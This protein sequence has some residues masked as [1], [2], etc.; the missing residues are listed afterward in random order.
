MS[1]LLPLKYTRGG[2]KVLKSR[3]FKHFTYALISLAFQSACESK[4]LLNSKPTLLASAPTVAPLDILYAGP[5][6]TIIVKGQNFSTDLSLFI[7]DE[8]IALSI[9]DRERAS[10][11]LPE[12]EDN[13]LYRLSF[14]SSGRPLKNF[15][16][17][18]STALNDLPIVPVGLQYICE[19]LI[20]K[21]Q[22]G[23]ILRG[24]AKCG[25]NLAKPCAHD[26]EVNC[27]ANE[28]FKAAATLDAA[29][30]ILPGESLAGIHGSAPVK[31]DC[32]SDGEGNCVVD[33]LAYKAAKLSLFSPYDIRSSTRIAGVQGSLPNCSSDG[34]LG[35]INVGPGYAAASLSG[36]AAKILSG[37]SLAGISGVAPGPPSNCSVD[38]DTNCV[39][40][41]AFPAVVK[42][43]VSAGLIKAGSIIAGINGAY[44]SATY[45]LAGNTALVDLTMFPNQMTSDGAFEFFDSAGMRYAGGGDSDLA[46]INLRSGTILE[47]LALNGIMPAVLPTPPTS[48]TTMYFTSPDRVTLNWTAVPGAAGYLLVS[49][50]GAAVTF[51]P[52]PGQTYLPGLQGADTILYVGSNLTF[53][54]NAINTGN[55]YNYAVFSYDA[56]HFYSAVPTRAINP[57]LFC[58][59]LAGGTWTAVPGDATYGTSDF[60]VQKFGAKD[61]FGIPTSQA[62]SSPWVNITQ[63][64]SISA[65]RALG[66]TFDLISNNEWLTIGAN[67]AKT[68]SNWSSGVVGTGTLNRG[69]SDN[70]PSS[71]CAAS[72]DDSLAWLQTDCTPKNSSGD[73]FIQ[74][75]T[76]SL[77]TGGIIWDFSGNVWE[78]TSY[79]IP[80]NNAKPFVSSDG[81][82]ANAWRELMDVNS[83]FS[84]MT[85][86]ELI[87]THAQKSFWNDSW[88]SSTYGMGQYLS[89]SPGGGG[90]MLRGGTYAEW[91]NSGIFATHLADLSS[92]SYPTVGFRCVARPP[93]L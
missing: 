20:F 24:E 74:K 51:A 66:P 62:S 17:A 72:N 36:A 21:D 61:V 18:K 69:H 73:V 10:F 86:G 92:L 50:P 31:P 48:L 35:C 44:P 22:N 11:V 42:A 75:R 34:E 67:I 8:P 88:S 13:E 38:N 26:G 33:G 2:P 56:N 78:W 23:A 40:T 15:S 85:R 93:V 77:S 63:T 83:G 71:A 37:Q 87:V 27:L 7:N 65:C 39:A 82:A 5:G 54:H 4:A 19:D 81:G 12:S 47:N 76:H 89:G 6:E 58:Q 70:D 45:P 16:L 28:D 57:L 3:S 52:N 84:V 55:S 49:R 91:S 68:A 14:K 43:N 29:R 64:A 79:V 80:D 25:S 90:A 41:P 60:C 9:L 30:K 53:L 1:Y 46:P 59:G 32:T